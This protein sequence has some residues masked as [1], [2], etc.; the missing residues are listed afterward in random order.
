M[1]TK[2]ILLRLIIIM[3]IMLHLKT[4]LLTSERKIFCAVHA[5]PVDEAPTGE[6][7]VAQCD[8]FVYVDEPPILNNGSSWEIYREML[9][10]AYHGYLQWNYYLILTNYKALIDIANLRDRLK[11]VPISVPVYAILEDLAGAFGVPP[12]PSTIALN[13]RA[14]QAMLFGILYNLPECTANASFF[15]CAARLQLKELT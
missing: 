14:V 11:N 13:Y 3:L 6:F 5:S 10:I 8:E 4:S 7:D 15:E 2:T 1:C 9:L 12:Y